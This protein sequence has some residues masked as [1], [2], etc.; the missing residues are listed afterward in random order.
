M[1][2][3]CF[4][5]SE[6]AFLIGGELNFRMG[7]RGGKAAFVWRDLAGGFGEACEFVATDANKAVVDLFAQYMYRALYEQK[8]RKNSENASAKDLLEFVAE[9][10]YVCNYNGLFS[11]IFSDDR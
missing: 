1:P 5:E 6:R 11:F 7:L 4:I 9:A 8:Y 3:I 10:E 2:N